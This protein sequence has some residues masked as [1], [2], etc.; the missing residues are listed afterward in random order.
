MVAA[1]FTDFMK[2]SVLFS[3]G[4]PTFVAIAQLAGMA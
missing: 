2:L 1:S 3:L 4:T